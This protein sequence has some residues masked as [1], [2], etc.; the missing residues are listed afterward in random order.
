MSLC[1]GKGSHFDRIQRGKSIRSHVVNEIIYGGNTMFGK[2]AFAHFEIHMR[3]ICPIAFRLKM[4][5]L[6]G[7]PYHIQ[8]KRRFKYGCFP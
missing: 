4:V 7:S 6:C 5:N 2:S 3:N 1:F 8:K